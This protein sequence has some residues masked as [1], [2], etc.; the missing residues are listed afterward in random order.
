MARGEASSDTNHLPMPNEDTEPHRDRPVGMGYS[1]WDRGRSGV[2]GIFKTFNVSRMVMTVMQRSKGHDLDRG[3]T[4]T[5][6]LGRP[7]LSES[8]EGEELGI[9]DTGYRRMSADAR[10]AAY[11]FMVVGRLTVKVTLQN[12][13]RRRRKGACSCRRR[14][15]ATCMPDMPREYSVGIQRHMVG[16]KNGPLLCF[17]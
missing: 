3:A 12:R 8:F 5:L 10:D 4:T 17:S 2:E 9:G 16:V 1:S 7:Q 14:H 6:N 13:L 11:S 15:M